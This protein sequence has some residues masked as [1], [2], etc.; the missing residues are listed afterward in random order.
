MRDTS[1]ALLVHDT[2]SFCCHDP[3]DRVHAVAT[4]ASAGAET[5][6][7]APTVTEATPIAQL[8]AKPADFQG[9]T[10]RVEGIVT[11]VCTMMGCWMALAP[12]DAPK[13]P[14]ILIK[15]DDGVIVFPT[16]ARGKRAT[17]Q[18]VVE[19]VG[20]TMRRARRRP[21]SMRNT[22]AT[23]RPIARQAGRSKRPAPS[24]IEEPLEETKKEKGK[25]NR[26]GDGAP[27]ERAVSIRLS[28]FVFPLLI[29]LP[30]TAEVSSKG[31]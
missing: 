2:H 27:T 24:C 3:A 16:S 9:K 13:G 21:A 31:R 20:T 15:V 30:S 4:G 5:F 12:T 19:R 28:F 23:P 17:A 29:V 1:S 8:L 26:D 14:A 22:R 11:G 7:T 6:G 10:V 25:P 18:G